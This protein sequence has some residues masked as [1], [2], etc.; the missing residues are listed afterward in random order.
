M[1]DFNYTVKGGD[2]LTQIFLDKAAENGYSGDKSKINW[3]NV[4]SIFDTIQKEEEAEGQRLY[5]GG[6][7]KTSKGWRTSYKLHVGDII[8][9]TKQQIDKIYTAM[10][11]KKSGGAAPTGGADGANGAGGAALVGTGNQTRGLG[12]ICK[13]VADGLEEFIFLLVAVCALIVNGAG[14]GTAGLDLRYHA[15]IVT[16]RFKMLLYAF[17]A[18]T[19]FYLD[20]VSFASN[21]YRFSLGQHKIVAG[22]LHYLFRSFTARANLDLITVGLTGCRRGFGLGQYEFVNVLASSRSQYRR[23][24]QQKS[25]YNRSNLFHSQSPLLPFDILHCIIMKEIFQC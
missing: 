15:H 10:G 5:R 17:A 1:S 7:D 20:T 11:F 22:C 2:R 12:G 21:G 13:R 8:S 6:N 4:L 24:Q 25:Q 14:A 18:G 19:D 16:G 3:M 9:L 23:E